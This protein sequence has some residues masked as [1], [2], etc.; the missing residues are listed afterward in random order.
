M[1][2]SVVADKHFYGNPNMELLLSIKLGTY[3]NRKLEQAVRKTKVQDINWNQLGV[4]NKSGRLKHK[5]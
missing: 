5:L 2:T 4:S 3:E 1:V